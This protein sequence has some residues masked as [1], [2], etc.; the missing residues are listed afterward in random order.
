LGLDY[1]EAGYPKAAEGDADAAFFRDPPVLRHARLAAF[2]ATRRKDTGADADAGLRALADSGAPAAVIFGKAWLLHVTDVLGCG[3]E[4][5]LRMIEDSVRFL[6]DRGREVIFDA[7]HFFDGWRQDAAYAFAA[8]EAARRGGADIL[9][10]CDTR[11]GVL[12]DEAYT[13]V[14]EVRGQTGAPLGI[15]A[16]ND[17]GM[18]AAVSVMAVLAG[19]THVQGTLCGFGERC[20]NADLVSV[21]LA[22]QAKR[23][24]D[25]L[26]PERL[27]ELTHAARR[28]AELCNLA[29]PQ[30]QPYVGASA[31]AHKAGMHIDGVMKNPETFEHISPE[32]VGNTRR[33]MITD[34]S[35]R[36]QVLPVLRRV[37]PDAARDGAEMDLILRALRE[38]QG[39]GYEAAGAGF[40][41]MIRDLLGLYEPAF[42]LV[43]YTV[44]SE[45]HANLP[46]GPA[47]AVVKVSV[48]GE[49]S[50]AAGEGEGP[51]NALDGALR[52]ALE[53]FYPRLR[54]MRLTDYKVRVLNPT[55]AS[56]ASVRVLI[57]STD[58]A[59]D[60]STLGVSTDIISASWQA[61]YDSIRYYL[62]GF[63]TAL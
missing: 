2:G 7:E 19:C 15:H 33:L 28:V 46:A 42:E 62:G 32:T 39:C 8:L 5:N 35:G 61:L 56:A 26:P 58:G 52:T 59:R 1:I 16:H 37:K 60:W 4:E 41:L 30:N 44:F 50:L 47:R 36:A 24:Y 43:N 12:P 29:V 10:L 55:A 18:A 38:R 48:R 45:G 54:D 27:P 21:T 31:F 14:R 49:E 6:K 63:H 17:A 51:V 57:A 40:E 11:G 20:G 53:P 13:I 23:G 22:L 3:P 34:H 25:C 9:C